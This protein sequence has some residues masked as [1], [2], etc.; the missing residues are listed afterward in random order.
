MNLQQLEK[1][2]KR[3]DAVF[4]I[5]KIL[6]QKIDTGHIT[7]YYQESNRGYHL[8]HSKKGA[9]HMA[10]NFDN[11]FNKN[12]YNEQARIINKYI[13]QIHTKYVLELASG[14]GFNTQYLARIN[15]TTNFTGI[16]TTPLY[17]KQAQISCRGLN[18]IMIVCLI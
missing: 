14:K 10:L 5:E 16:D 6:Q 3:V 8:I 11:Q 18:N 4:G 7:R 9:V 1:W 17:V 2:L 15:P 13:K 12:G